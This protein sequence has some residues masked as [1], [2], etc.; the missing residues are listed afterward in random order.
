MFINTHYAETGMTTILIVIPK[1]KVQE[2]KDKYQ[3]LL[4]DFNSTDKE[5]W[6]K[7]KLAE[8]KMAH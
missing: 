3:T 8:I 7:R 2:F 5:M 4:L 6:E 1:K